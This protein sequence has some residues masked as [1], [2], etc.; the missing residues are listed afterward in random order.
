VTGLYILGFFFLTCNEMNPSPD[1][2]ERQAMV[3]SCSR[4]L[5]RPCKWSGCDVVMDSAAKL[6]KHF[7][8]EHRPRKSSK[9]DLIPFAFAFARS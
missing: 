9:V 3:L 4:I 5:E 6:V 8:L 2:A 7:A 1:D